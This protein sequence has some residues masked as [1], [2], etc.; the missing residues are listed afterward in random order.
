[1]Y[2]SIFNR[3]P[4]I[5]TVSSKVRHFSTFWPPLVTPL[6]QSRY[7]SHGWKEDSML[8]KC[9]A[10]YLQ[11][12]PCDISVASDWFSTVLVKWMSSFYHILLFPGY[13]PGTIAVNVTLLERGFN[14]CKTPHCIHP[15]IFNRFWDIARY[16]SEIATFS[17]SLAFNAPIGCSRWNSRKKFGPQKTR[18]MGLPGSEDSLTIG[19]AVLIQYHHVMDGQT[20]VQPIAKTCFSM[21]DAYKKLTKLLISKF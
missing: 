18:I 9:L 20:D 17:Y 4:V 7:M 8:V 12:F 10:A 16:W 6:G 21:A 2:P 5:Q 1:M 11:P 13:T 19:W 15:S 14:A 3:F